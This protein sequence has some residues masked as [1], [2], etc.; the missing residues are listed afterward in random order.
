MTTRKLNLMLLG[1]LLMLATPACDD[2]AGVAVSFIQITNT[3]ED[4]ANTSHTFGFVAQN[5][6]DGK[7]A[8]TFNGQEFVNANDF[9][10]FPLTGSW[11]GGRITFTVQRTTG[12]VT[13]N[14]TLPGDD[15]S[16]L[17]FT[18]SAGSIRIRKKF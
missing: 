3:W 8:G 11:A 17:S 7:T 13:Y 5:D 14:A 16:E 1:A 12:S 4:V 10:G 6:S 2:A 18:S 9:V 15:A